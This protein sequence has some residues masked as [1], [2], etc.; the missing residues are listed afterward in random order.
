MHFKWDRDRQKWYGQLSLK[1]LE[2]DDWQ[3]RE[4]AAEA[5]GYLGAPAAPEANA[6]T[7]S[8]RPTLILDDISAK[9]DWLLLDLHIVLIEELY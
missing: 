9:M 6:R 4:H 8:I 3:V 7:I 1:N 2:D 5:L